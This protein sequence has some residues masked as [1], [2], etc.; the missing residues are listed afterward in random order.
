M[1]WLSKAHVIKGC[2]SACAER[3]WELYQLKSN[4]RKLGHWIY[5]LKGI[6]GHHHFFFSFLLPPP[7]P[8]PSSLFLF[9]FF[10]LLLFLFLPLIFFSLLLLHQLL[11]SCNH[12]E[13]CSLLF[14]WIDFFSCILCSYDVF[15][16][17]RVKVTKWLWIKAEFMSYR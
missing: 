10:F 9:L 3:W 5:A 14:F 12:H 1:E 15:C 8:P 13:V 11:T 16:D 4:R 7:P 17:H 2:L 6:L